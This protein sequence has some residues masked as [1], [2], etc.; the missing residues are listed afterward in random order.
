MT[1]H[2]RKSLP[3][4]IFHAVTFEVIA[5]LICGP[6]FA[7]L[8]HTSV[9]AMSGLTLA[10]SGIAMLWNI[11]YNALFDRAQRRLGVTRTFGVR[12]LHAIGFELGLV[13]ASVPL[14][15]VWL[16]IALWPA[17]V[18]DLGLILFFLPYTIVFN[19]AYDAL[20]A[21]WFAASA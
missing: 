1:T 4:R 20:R 12:A 19:A 2:L 17:F 8:M 3:E 16:G 11:V 10:I 9:A 7:W 5:L 15:A 18:L 6:L 14:A 13:L 21:R